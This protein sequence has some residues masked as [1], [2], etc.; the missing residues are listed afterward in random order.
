MHRVSLQEK[1]LSCPVCIS[2][3]EEPKALPECAHNVC[4]KCL[5]NI[6]AMS[7][8]WQ[9]VTCPVCRVDSYLPPGG[10][11]DLP[12]NHFMKTII[13][14]LPGRKE[15]Q[16]IKRALEQCE[17]GLTSS[18]SHVDDCE[19]S[20]A[21]F[22]A[23]LQ[24]AQQAKK[25]VSD[26]TKYLIDIIQKECTSLT[27]E[28]DEKIENTSS[29]LSNVRREKKKTLYTVKESENI[30]SETRR[31]IERGN[32]QEIVGKEDESV[33]KLQQ[34]TA[35]L[36]V[37]QTF[38]FPDVPE[39]IHFTKASNEFRTGKGILG[40]LSRDSIMEVN[41]NNSGS[42]L[43]YLHD[44]NPR[45]PMPPCFRRSHSIRG[46][47][48]KFELARF[49]LSSPRRSSPPVTYPAGSDYMSLV[50]GQRSSYPFTPL[51][52]LTLPRTSSLRKFTG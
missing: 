50:R 22:K 40:S 37:N 19:R 52:P 44:W 25:E 18:K 23:T 13:D 49:T 5:S 6:A 34:R 33:S 36:A 10:V 39:N 27:T 46:V 24:I 31:L 1:D 16:S 2:I 20:I 21:A 35:V 38:K 47:V 30:V 26:H 48:N 7:S 43:E 11:A 28:I 12:T 3:F 41:E 8:R 14:G 45:Q 29:L 4:Q 15:I 17:E 51:P 9:F 32:V 42:D